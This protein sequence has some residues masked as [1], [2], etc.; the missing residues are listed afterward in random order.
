MEKLYAAVLTVTALA[1]CGIVG[2]AEKS[3]SAPVSRG[4]SL[5][6]RDNLKMLS[7][8]VRF[9]ADDHSNLMPTR[10]DLVKNATYCFSDPPVSV[11]LRCPDG[12]DYELLHSGG[13]QSFCFDKRTFSVPMCEIPMLRCPVH[14]QV[15][16]EDG[17]WVD[18]AD[19]DTAESDAERESRRCAAN[20]KATGV[21]VRMY[22]DEH[23]GMPSADDLVSG[24]YVAPGTGVFVCPQGGQYEF[25]APRGTE[26]PTAGVVRILRCP[27]HGCMLTSD[28]H[29]NDRKGG[30][31]DE[32]PAFADR[33]DRA[34]RA[35]EKNEVKDFIQCVPQRTDTD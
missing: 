17:R 14:G 5:R 11:L 33:R 6:C 2:A 32:K 26:I 23:R 34:P 28:G 20:L 3:S 31:K 16:M 18:L 12:A 8:A 35:G 10:Q 30:E 25:V 1:V 7:V 9:Y 13:T 21:F 29:V 19:W 27:R 22:L 24:K 15:V 4:S